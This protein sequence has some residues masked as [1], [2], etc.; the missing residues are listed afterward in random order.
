VTAKVNYLAYVETTTPKYRIFC[1]L[2]K[3]TYSVT[4]LA[5][6]SK[7]TAVMAKLVLSC[8]FQYD[9]TVYGVVL[10]I[11]SDCNLL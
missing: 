10:N 8:R 5:T 9:N 2:T 3:Q 1:I 6:D 11:S 4:M 7:K